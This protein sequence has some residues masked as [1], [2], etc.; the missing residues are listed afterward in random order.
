LNYHK[1][2]VK[3]QIVEKLFDPLAVFCALEQCSGNYDNLGKVTINEFL[4]WYRRYPCPCGGYGALFLEWIDKVNDTRK[5]QPPYHS[6]GNG[7]AMR[8]SP[9]AYF[10]TSIEQCMELSRKVTEVTHNHPEG[11]KGA[12]A[13]AV[14]IY[15]S[16]HGKTKKEILEYIQTYYYLLDKSCDEIRIDYKFNGSC[17][18]TVPESIQAF[19]E[20]V[21]YEDAIRPTISLGGDADTMG[22]ITGAIAGAHFGVPQE[23]KQKLFEHLDDTCKDVVERMIRKIDSLK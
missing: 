21:D 1:Q 16:L 10:A 4:R 14:A 5:Y 12:E 19:L 22:A 18:G 20:S 8:I 2:F 15:M 23:M 6:F 17:Q 11:I 9:V 13:T 7:A 3:I